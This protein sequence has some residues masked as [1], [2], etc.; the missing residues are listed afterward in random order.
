MYSSHFLSQKP[1]SQYNKS[2]IYNQDIYSDFSRHNLYINRK[3]LYS[4]ILQYVPADVFG[5]HQVI[6]YSHIKLFLLFPLSIAQCLHLEEDH[7]CY[8]QR[9]IPVIDLKHTH[10]Y[11]YLYISL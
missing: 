10:T 5:H 7:V 1:V 3:Y 6:L 11:I 9:K 2:Q 8:I 4:F